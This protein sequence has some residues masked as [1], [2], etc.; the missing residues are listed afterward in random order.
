MHSSTRARLLLAAAVLLLSA[1][2]A[3]RA[4]ETDD[5]RKFGYVPGTENG[6]GNWSR[7]DPRWAKCNTGNMQS[8]IDLSHERLMR[9][10]GYLD[11]SYLPAEASMVNR[12]HDI[13]VKFMGNAGR[14]VIN[15]KA[16]KLKQ[17]HW[18]TPSEHTV[19][20][21]RYDM[22]LHLVHDDG[23]SNTAVIGNLYQIGNPDP[24]LLMLEPFIR[25][26]ADT[27]DKSEPIGVVDP[28]LA[29][30]PDAVYYRYMGSLT[31]PPCTE[32]VIWTVF[33]RVGLTF[34]KFISRDDS[35]LF[36]PQGYEN[37]ARPLQKVNNRNISIFIPDP[38]KD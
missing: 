10:L 29:K 33:K 22:E 4:Q 13:E 34:H 11:Y 24:F 38:K 37:N 5:E 21:R 1:A 17:L 15:G 35:L 2:P 23:N 25:R 31:T 18:H 27:K 32:G 36:T 9:N 7:L 12:G 30:S 3:A 28:Q 19:N 14:V 16:Y 26:I 8:P 20:G 6:P